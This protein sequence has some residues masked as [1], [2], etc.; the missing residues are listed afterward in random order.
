MFDDVDTGG[1]YCCGN[2]LKRDCKSGHG[3]PPSYLQARVRRR[4]QCRS[5]MHCAC[6]ALL[7]LPLGDLGKLHAWCRPVPRAPMGT[8]EVLQDENRRCEMLKLFPSGEKMNLTRNE[9]VKIGVTFFVY[10][11]FVLILRTLLV[12]SLSRSFV[13]FFL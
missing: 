7:L 13:T 9:K 8:R 12:T 11:S 1:V 10:H 6:V 5:E 3:A 2:A 4:G